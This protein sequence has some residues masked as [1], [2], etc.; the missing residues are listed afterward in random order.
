MKF[1][2]EPVEKE[3]VSSLTAIQ[4]AFSNIVSALA[5]VKSDSMKMLLNEIISVPQMSLVELE[6]WLADKN[7]NLIA[8][9]VK[10]G[11]KNYAYL[12]E[13]FKFKK[14]KAIT[15]NETLVKKAF[16]EMMPKIALEKKTNPTGEYSDLLAIYLD[17]ATLCSQKAIKDGLIVAIVNYVLDDIYRIRYV[18]ERVAANDYLINRFVGLV[19][20][21][22]DAVLLDEINLVYEKNW[23]IPSVEQKEKPS[24]LYK[25]MSA[26]KLNND[27]FEDIK[28][29]DFKDLEFVN[30]E[31]VFA[32]KNIA[33]KYLPCL[34]NYYLLGD[35]NGN[36]Y[37]VDKKGKLFPSALK[38]F[39]YVRHELYNKT[40][41]KID[42]P[43]L[44]SCVTLNMLRK[45]VL[46]EQYSFYEL[47]DAV[48][49]IETMD[50]SLTG[51]ITMTTFELG[52]NKHNELFFG[53]QNYRF[54]VKDIA[55]FKEASEFKMNL[56][57]IQCERNSR[58]EA[59][60]NLRDKMRY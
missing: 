55:D 21:A 18:S 38:S 17:A 57:L 49:M 22:K 60:Y 37:L 46:F 13:T 51:L 12:E 35:K 32:K 58:V 14:Q 25:T 24:D 16:Y 2:Q 9:V 10:N 3:L 28:E 53:H 33:T 6:A 31:D 15:R 47:G 42:Y 30:W 20:L 34:K 48:G 56:F 50:I 45:K 29:L 41:N 23:V 39:S 44:M 19:M 59:D 43:N 4:S 8:S 5:G 7:N 40:S 54:D 1:L 27:D 52:I 11:T 36:I 26:K